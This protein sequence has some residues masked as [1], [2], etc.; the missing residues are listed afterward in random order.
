MAAKLLMGEV[1]LSA[2]AVYP[3]PTSTLTGAYPNLPKPS[4]LT[5]IV[6]FCFG[7]PKNNT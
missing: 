6:F 4:T 1:S 2:I 3:S 7:N 5:R